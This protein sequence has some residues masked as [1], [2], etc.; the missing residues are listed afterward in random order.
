MSLRQSQPARHAS[1]P[2]SSRPTCFVWAEV[3]LAKNRP[4]CATVNL[5]Y[6]VDLRLLKTQSVP[7]ATRAAAE[8]PPIAKGAKLLPDG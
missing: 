8:A 1:R 6:L 3:L 5:Y 4:A 7:T 2:A